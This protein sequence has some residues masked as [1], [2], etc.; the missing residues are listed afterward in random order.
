MCSLPLIFQSQ[1]FSPSPFRQALLAGQ[2]PTPSNPTLS[3]PDSMIRQF[4]TWPLEPGLL[5]ADTETVPRFEGQD[6]AEVPSPP[7]AR[8]SG[9]ELVAA[10]QGQQGPEPPH[11]SFH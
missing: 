9:L 6:G 8:A 11:G 5:S 7:G 4:L 3:F 1:D 2:L 10:A